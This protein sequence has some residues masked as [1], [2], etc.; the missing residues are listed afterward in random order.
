MTYITFLCAKQAGNRVDKAYPEFM[1]THR[2][3]AMALNRLLKQLPVIRER[4]LPQM[5]DSAG[6]LD[7]YDKMFLRLIKQPDTGEDE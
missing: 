7:W 5:T 6:F 2:K 3:D 1:K 4:L